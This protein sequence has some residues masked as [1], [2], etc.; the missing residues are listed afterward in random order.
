MVQA[1][2]QAVPRTQIASNVWDAGSLDFVPL[3]QG[4][5]FWITVNHGD[6]TPY[7]LRFRDASLFDWPIFVE[8]KRP[9]SDL[10]TF[11]A[12]DTASVPVAVHNLLPRWKM[13][14]LE[15]IYNGA[16]APRHP[17]WAFQYDLAK[18]QLIS[19]QSVRRETRV[20]RARPYYAGVTRL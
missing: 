8:Y 2:Y 16:A 7:K 10:T 11:A 1:V 3:V 19:A 14:V 5:D 13:D 18:K 12:D 20:G 6:A 15:T 4:S 17:D 9:V